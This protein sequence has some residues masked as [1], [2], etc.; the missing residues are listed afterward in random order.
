MI[1]LDYT[2]PAISLAVILAAIAFRYVPLFARHQLAAV[3][4]FAHARTCHRCLLVHQHNGSA[5]M[6]CSQGRVLS[7]A[8]AGIYLPR[9]PRLSRFG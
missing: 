8:V 7:E 9:L 1:D 5:L 4:W 2:G 3:R 6:L